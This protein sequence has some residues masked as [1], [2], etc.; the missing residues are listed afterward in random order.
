MSH[1]LWSGLG[2]GRRVSSC[3]VVD[4]W[5]LFGWTK[6]EWASEAWLVCACK[7]VLLLQ[8]SLKGLQGSG[9]LAGL[10][11]ELAKTHVHAY[12]RVKDIQ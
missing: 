3:L 1:D 2:W 6:R 9:F 8:R 10:S 5:P 11:V 4:T 12:C 7:L